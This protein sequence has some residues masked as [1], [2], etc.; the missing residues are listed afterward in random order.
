MDTTELEPLSEADLESME[1]MHEMEIPFDVDPEEIHSNMVVASKFLGGVAKISSDMEKLKSD[2]KKVLNWFAEEEA[3][4]QKNDDF[5]RAK[6]GQ[7]LYAMEQAG[8]KKPTIKTW[9]GSAYYQSTKKF[10]WNGKTNTDNDIVAY[11]KKAGL[12]VEV[13]EKVSLS[14]VK[15]VLSNDPKSMIELE[16]SETPNKSVVIRVK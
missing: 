1:I 2:K 6:I 4:L 10:D 7:A 9:A 3:K 11:A 15:A 5:L 8:D 16:V 13:I 12:E 14:K